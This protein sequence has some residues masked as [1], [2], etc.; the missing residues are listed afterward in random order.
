[1]DKK[2]LL[3]VS[4]P[5]D[6]VPVPMMGPDGDLTMGEVRVRGL[7]RSEW[8]TVGKITGESPGQEEVNRGEAF[9]VSVALLDPS[10]TL[11][12]AREWLA[13]APNSITSAVVSRI[14]ELTGARGG[15]A[16][17]AYKSLRS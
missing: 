13:D 1:M 14:M 17:D 4:H 5:E 8:F 15:A 9:A 7:S 16:K 10:L 12:E 2:A 6:T 11:E 3:C